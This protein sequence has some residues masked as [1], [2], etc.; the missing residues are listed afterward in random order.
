MTE[1]GDRGRSSGTSRASRI[2]Q[3]IAEDFFGDRL[4]LASRDMWREV[5]D[6][7]PTG[8]AA[9]G[10]S[11]VGQTWLNMPEVQ[12]AR[13]IR[14][15]GGSDRVVRLF[16]TFISAMDRVRDANKL[17]Q[18]AMSLYEA[19]PAAFDPQHVAGFEFG[20]LH[21]LL[22]STGVSQKH[23]PDTGAWLQ[24]AQSLSAGQESP[25]RR[26][27][28]AGHGDAQELLCDLK[29]P[30]ESGRA[31]FPQLAGPKIRLMWIRMLVTPGQAVVD[32]IETVPVAVD[33]QVRRVTEN[34]GV[35]TTRGLRL[36]KAK[37]IIHQAWLEAVSKADIGG[38]QGI[39]GT[40]AAL[41]PALWF[42]GKHG[43]DHCEKADRKVHFGRVCDHCVRFSGRSSAT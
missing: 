20:K 35:T 32:R 26:V 14:A 38:P 4:E 13:N 27:I 34:L 5:S 18:A 6:V 10:R 19:H 1:R 36:R 37:P 7:A 28:D 3:L 33:V 22:K 12:A 17:W 15:G 29:A 8:S 2:A 21:D 24:I 41:D 39:T 43:C 42:F 23:R 40:C 16:L 31:R 9:T 25:V 11:A 30:D